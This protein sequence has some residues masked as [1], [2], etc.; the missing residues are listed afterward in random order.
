MNSRA[1]LVSLVVLSFSAVLAGCS[2]TSQSTLRV[3]GASVPYFINRT[4]TVD[5]EY[6]K[7][8]RCGNSMPLLCKCDSSRWGKCI[9]QCE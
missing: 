7:R 4:V 2:A 6:V 1:K 5:R 3:S 8:Y 9:C